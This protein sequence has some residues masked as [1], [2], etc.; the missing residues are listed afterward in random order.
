MHEERFLPFAC[1]FFSPLLCPS[2]HAVMT[3]YKTALHRRVRSPH[4]VRA[5]ETLNSPTHSR[6]PT[7]FF[8]FLQMMEHSDSS[9]QARRTL[10]FYAPRTFSL[11]HSPLAFFCLPERSDSATTHHSLLSIHSPC[12]F[13]MLEHSD[14]LNQERR[15]KH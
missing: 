12:G 7:P 10:L 8:A 14:S 2:T 9:N 5:P 11:F 15:T 1:L 4:H 3:S 13:I 6:E